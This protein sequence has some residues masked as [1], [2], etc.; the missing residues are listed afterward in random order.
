MRIYELSYMAGHVGLLGLSLFAA[1][2]EHTMQ[3]I[4]LD[5][6][7]EWRDDQTCRFGTARTN[8]KSGTTRCCHAQENDARFRQRIDGHDS[9]RM[10]ERRP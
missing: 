5:S 7:Q 8:R 1:I 9:Q 2:E 3:R 6:C 4:W 10:L